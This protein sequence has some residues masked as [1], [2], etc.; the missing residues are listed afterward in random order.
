M[1]RPVQGVL[2]CDLA[3]SG[4]VLMDVAS[5]ASAQHPNP[6]PTLA[7]AKRENGIS[8]AMPFCPT[9]VGRFI[10]LSVAIFTAL[11]ASESSTAVGSSAA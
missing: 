8:S 10:L 4:V 1:V 3:V 7:T 6:T 11:R 5:S 9:V 2:H